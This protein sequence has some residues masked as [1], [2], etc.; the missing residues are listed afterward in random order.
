VPRALTALAALCLLAFSACGESDEKKVDDTVREF[1]KATNSRDT[2]KFCDELV[3]QQFLEQSTGAQ[4]SK[5]RDACH[6]QLKSLKGLK[7]G[8]DK[9]SATKVNGDKATVRAVLTTQ[10]Q[11][12]DQVFRLKKEDGD[13]KL[14][15][16]A[17]G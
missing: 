17:G 10:G 11:K 6:E 3:S 1:V 4:G 8:L 5:A 13:W 15:G 12:Q 7:I 14:A 2:K 9:I 16:G